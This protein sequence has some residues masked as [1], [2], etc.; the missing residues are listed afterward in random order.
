MFDYSKAKHLLNNKQLAK[1]T[2]LKPNNGNSL[3]QDCSQ[4][5]QEGGSDPDVP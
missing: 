4:K 3:Q 2:T 5:D 1:K